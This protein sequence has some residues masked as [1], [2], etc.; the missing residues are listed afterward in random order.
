MS[1]LLVL[2]VC[3]AAALLL[4]TVHARPVLEC[5]D[6]PG[7]YGTH[8]NVSCDCILP[9]PTEAC[10]T[11]DPSNAACAR[12]TCIIRSGY[13]TVRPG[14]HVGYWFPL[15]RTFFTAPGASGCAP[16]DVSEGTR[17]S[18]LL[19]SG[20]SATVPSDSASPTDLA[21][22]P[23]DALGTTDAVSDLDS[24]VR[25][26]E[27][28]G[29][30]LQTV[31]VVEPLFSH[32]GLAWPREPDAG[33]RNRPLLSLDFPPSRPDGE[34]LDG[35]IDPS[36]VVGEKRLTSY[37]CGT[38]PVSPDASVIS[39]ACTTARAE[40]PGSDCLCEARGYEC[41]AAP[42]R[43]ARDS[44]WAFS[45]INPNWF[46]PASP[47][48]MPFVA[49]RRSPAS[50]RTF[51]GLSA[52][53]DLVP[54]PPR[55]EGGWF[56][57]LHPSYAEFLSGESCP[58]ASVTV[59][60]ASPTDRTGRS[61]NSINNF[62]YFAI[63][64]LRAGETRKLLSRGAE[65]QNGRRGADAGWVTV[66]CDAPENR[67]SVVVDYRCTLTPNRCEGGLVEWTGS[68]GTVCSAQVGP[69]ASA[70]AFDEPSPASFHGLTPPGRGDSDLVVSSTS[71]GTTGSALVFCP[72]V[73]ET[74]GIGPPKVGQG[75]CARTA[76]AGASMCLG[77]EVSWRMYMD[78][79][80]VCRAT[81]PAPLAGLH[82][83]VCVRR[84]SSVTDP[85]PP[86]E[87]GETCVMVPDPRWQRHLWVPAPDEPPPEF[88]VRD[89]YVP[90][91]DAWSSV[92]TRGG[93]SQHYSGTVPPLSPGQS[94]TVIAES[95]DDGFS[96][97]MVPVA[98]SRRSHAPSWATFRCETAGALPVHVPT[99]NRSPP[100]VNNYSG[101]SDRVRYGR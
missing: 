71:S 56:T 15:V 98:V 22:G 40:A 24:G 3:V 86:N 91:S 67:R 97:G 29:E 59:D 58:H 27:R 85:L 5:V 54:E 76:A 26:Y 20:F 78:S 31:A 1:R 70:E 12:A 89:C 39:R 94:F 18:A 48:W 46:G 60:G 7:P 34:P 79:R 63:P 23:A 30:V 37:K 101:P 8:I 2:V 43:E 81:G 41:M 73:V 52:S 50:L 28:G 62:C 99:L 64:S 77:G 4:P 75:S 84:T 10:P 72:Y 88:T 51:L 35:C 92:S 83:D 13:C 65:N 95:H 33:G 57:P 16:V 66:R 90:K 45:G 11:R 100:P 47:R 74:R 80:R 96:S 82:T 93:R 17:A 6:P 32:H 55:P 25:V 68:D 49:P 42:E 87:I 44:R 21:G 53:A 9:P 69:V 38:S 36:G 19:R 61:G 14:E